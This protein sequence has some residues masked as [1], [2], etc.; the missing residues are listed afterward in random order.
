MLVGVLSDTHDRLPAIR[1]LLAAFQE[2]GVGL[3]LHAGDY[4][5]PFSLEPFR[6]AGVALAG[7]FGRNDGDREGLR[8]A[9]QQGMGH[10][11][12]DGPH[13]LALGE[14]KVLLVHD[15]G[16]VAERSVLGH[17]VVIHG[18][19][20]KQEMKT[21]G[22]TLIINPGEACGWVY[23]AC[24]GAVVDLQSKHVEFIKVEG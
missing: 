7:V 17:S 22:D 4:C 10:E 21:R 15:I 23:G 3:V 2:R 13:S 5:A 18:T 11:L 6:D 20:H 8:A 19:T 24:T 16:D 14:H 1:A 9:A 12:F